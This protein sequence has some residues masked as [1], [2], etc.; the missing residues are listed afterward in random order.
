MSRTAQVERK[1]KETEI[2]VKLNLD[3]EGNVKIDTGVGFFDHML[4]AFGVHGGLDLEV[5]VKG[6]LYVDAHHTWR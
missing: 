5:N 3:G 4:T 6:D 1:T 2:S